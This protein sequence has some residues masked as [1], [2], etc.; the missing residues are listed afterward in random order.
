MRWSIRELGVW[1]LESGVRS[2]LPFRSTFEFCYDGLTS[3]T[4]LKRGISFRSW[5]RLLNGLA[6]LIRRI[7][8][9]SQAVVARFTSADPWK[10][11]NQRKSEERDDPAIMAARIIYGGKLTYA[12][13]N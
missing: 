13:S 7:T 3:T 2:T 10:G 1:S 4:S 8:E 11:R 5:A 9:S 12:F 6:F